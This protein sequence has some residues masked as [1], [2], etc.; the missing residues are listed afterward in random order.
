[1]VK[2]LKREGAVIIW[3]SDATAAKQRPG[4]PTQELRKG[5]DERV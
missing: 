4:N 1:V 2:G 3:N 5:S